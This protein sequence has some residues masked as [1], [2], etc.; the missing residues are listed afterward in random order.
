MIIFL[1]NGL[2]SFVVRFWVEWFLDPF[3]SLLIN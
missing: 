3:F 1:L 2:V